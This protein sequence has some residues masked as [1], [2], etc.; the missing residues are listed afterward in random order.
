MTLQQRID[1]LAEL[2][3]CLLLDS[4]E[5]QQ[6]LQ[7]AYHQNGWFSPEQSQFMLD[8]IARD[9]L[10]LQSL[11]QWVAAYPSLLQD[12]ATPKRIGLVLAGNIPAVGLHD[13][14]SVFIT[15]NI[16]LLKYSDK[17]KVLIPFVLRLLEQINPHTAAYFQVVERVQQPDAVI[18][19]GSDN[20][21]LYFQQYFGKYPNIIRQNRHSVAVLS[22]NETPEALARLSQDVFRYYGLGC[23]SVSKIYVPQG[24]DFIPLMQNFDMYE[25]VM[26]NNKYKNNFDYNR[27]LY[28]LN[29]VPHW[30][31]DCILV[32]ENPALASRIATLHY[33]FYS[34]LETLQHHLNTDLDGK[35]QCI[36][37][38]IVLPALPN[39]PLGQTQSP[40]LWDYADG[41]DT[42]AFLSGS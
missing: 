4:P 30:I 15:G 16:A 2:G 33:S 42:V 1:A 24:Y 3:A 23:R 28:L 40:A 26:Q 25:Y 35:I 12:K 22:G 14:L 21:S 18:A 5:K 39:V 29:Q 32:L 7:L 6:T 11:Q 20:T 8:G 9:W 17:D 36:A 38:D 27:S 10:N 13:V 37:S 31:N 41:V 34:D 19:T